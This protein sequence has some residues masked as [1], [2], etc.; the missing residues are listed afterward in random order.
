M[1]S[2]SWAVGPPA[3]SVAPLHRHQSPAERQSTERDKQPQLLLPGSISCHPWADAYY[4]QATEESRPKFVHF[5]FIIH[6]PLTGLEVHLAACFGCKSNP[7]SFS[8]AVATE[9]DIFS[10][11]LLKLPLLLAVLACI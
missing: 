7:F 11:A 2:S 9:D 8:F 5:V 1:K 6:F 4:T 10:Q 3:L